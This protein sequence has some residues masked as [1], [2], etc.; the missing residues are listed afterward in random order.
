MMDKIRKGLRSDEGFTLV[1]LMVVV[2]IIAILMAIAI[3]TFLGARQKAQ[4]R[5]MQANLRNALTAEKVYYVDGEAYTSDKDELGALEPSLVFQG[6]SYPTAASESGDVYLKLG[7]TDQIVCVAG[8]SAS[9]SFFVIKDIVS[10]TNPGT[11]FYTATDTA[12]TA[13]SDTTTGYQTGGF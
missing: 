3:P 10:G 11:W 1:E 7:A 8:K 5:A 6:D 4:D 2:L 13:C 9:G 12:P